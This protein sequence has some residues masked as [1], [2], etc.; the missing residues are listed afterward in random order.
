MGSRRGERSVITG[1]AMVAA[2]ASSRINADMRSRAWSL[3]AG[4]QIW[5]DIAT[6]EDDVLG[7][8]S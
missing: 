4:A 8:R 7:L 3:H 1:R 6:I 2:A 5:G